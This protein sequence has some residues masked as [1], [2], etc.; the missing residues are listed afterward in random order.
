MVYHGC[1]ESRLMCWKLKHCDICCS[2]FLKHNGLCWRL[3]DSNYFYTGINTAHK[4]S[5]MSN[6]VCMHVMYTVVTVDTVCE[7]LLCIIKLLCIFTF[8]SESY[9]PH[10]TSMSTF[11]E[12]VRHGKIKF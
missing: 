5:C 2:Y 11:R 4:F 6:A 7:G 3:A 1:K 9:W 10:L 8:F 12:N